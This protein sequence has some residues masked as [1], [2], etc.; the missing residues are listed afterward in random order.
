[1]LMGEDTKTTQE[2]AVEMWK[3]VYANVDKA[4]EKATGPLLARIEDLEHRLDRLTRKDEK[5]APE[6]EAALSED[7]GKAEAVVN[8]TTPTNTPES[9]HEASDTVS[10]P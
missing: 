1:M 3:D 8:D 7:A 2:M 4:I 9:L 10:N 6:G 5:Q